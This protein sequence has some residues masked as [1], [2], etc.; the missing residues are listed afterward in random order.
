VNTRK[1]EQKKV[2]QM[3]VKLSRYKIAIG[4]VMLSRPQIEAA[5]IV[6]FWKKRLQDM[7]FCAHDFLG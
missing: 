1:V 4:N 2:Q 5:V 7:I 3:S 6:N